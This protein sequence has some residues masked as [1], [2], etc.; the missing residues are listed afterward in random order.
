M[1][2]AHSDACLKCT[3]CIAACPVYRKDGE[4]PGPK[5]LGPEWHRRHLAGTGDLMD[6]VDDCTFCQ[7]CEGACPVGVPVAHLIAEHKAAALPKQTWPMRVRDTVLTHPEWVAR[8]PVLTRATALVPISRWLKL[9]TRSQ[10]PSVRKAPRLSRSSRRAAVGGG[11][12]RVALFVDCF[13]RGFDTEAM[14]AAQAL[15]EVFGFEVHQVPRTSQCCGAAAYASGRV[16]QARRQ[17]GAM[18]QAIRGELRGDEVALITLNATCQGTIGEEWSKFLGL[19]DLPVPVIPFHVFALQHAPAGFWSTVAAANVDPGSWTW[20]HTTCRGRRRG[21]GAL[22]QLARRAGM[23]QVE[24]LD[25]ECCGAAGSYAF[26]A[27]HAETAHDIGQ[28]AAAQIHGRPGVIW[29][30]SGTCA[31]HLEQLAGRT[32]R[33]PAYWLWQAW[34]TS[35]SASATP[36]APAGHGEPRDGGS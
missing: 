24:P 34:L 2:M 36:P 32:A 31:V 28:P 35:Q 25:L 16:A 17:A 12:P 4:F 3:I 23:D 11:R 21:D 26:K 27:E 19:N 5:A 13:D 15:M 22:F 6:H 10:R 33:H 20:T 7:L 29:V 8:A 9:S 1:M 14:L 30:D 18:E